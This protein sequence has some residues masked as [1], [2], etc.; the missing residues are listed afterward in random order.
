M[1]EALVNIAAYLPKIA[2]QQP[3]TFGV[4]FP[5]TRDGE[6]RVAY[7]HFT[8]AQLDRECDR[9]AWA[10][11][12]YGIRRGDRVVL[13]VK[14]S[15]AFFALTFALF[16]M[17]TVPVFVD[18]GMGVKNL[19]KCL[20]EAEPDAFVGVP[21]AHVARLLLRWPRVRKLVT[22]GRK[23]WGGETLQNLCAAV[24]DKGAFA[25]ADTR[26]EDLAAILF[27]SG[28]TGPPKGAVYSHGI[29]DSQV[30][31][32]GKTYGIQPGEVDLATFPLFALF[33][34]ALGMTAIVPDMDATRPADVDPVKIFEAIENFGVTNMFGSPALLNTVSRYAVAN[35]VTCP[36]LRRVISAGAPVSP[37]V[38]RRMA[39]LMPEGV[40][41]FTP[42][43]ATESLPVCNIGSAVILA[44]TETLTDQGRGVC[45]GFPVEEMEVRI[46]AINDA[47]LETWDDRLALP[48]G[49]VGEVV[50]KGP[51][52]TRR[53]F[54]REQATREHKMKD[55]DQVRHR[56]GDLGYFDEQGRLWFC[57]RK[58]HRV[59]T[60]QRLLFTV[61]VEGVFNSHPDVYRSALVG[62]GADAAAQE[63][64]VFLELETNRASGKS[65]QAIISELRELALQFEHTAVIERFIV[66]PGFPVDI[67][68]NAKIFRE[69]LRA[70]LSG[71]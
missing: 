46:I 13:M 57:G 26:A 4:V 60:A 35:G 11:T 55:G 38:L 19:K 15:L 51:V 43:G 10:L 40:Q 33:A 42:Y 30:R 27:T 9:V 20:E 8:Y 68:H 23:L 7:T 3:H 22:V 47:E 37:A 17:G 41:V 2:A 65:E 69:K 32:L 6:G 66:H 31:L 36:S 48:P 1:S 50:V 34:P 25:T 70:E 18:P 21:K 16:K 28:S 64:V 44:E 49:E 12:E 56:M 53:Y 5:E 71:A 59:Q 29:F 63:P 39:R 54:N 67:R 61:Q 52:V 58:A 62:T 45:V 24:R 14:P